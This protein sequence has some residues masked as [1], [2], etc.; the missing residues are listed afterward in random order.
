MLRLQRALAKIDQIQGLPENVMYSGSKAL[1]R[2][3]N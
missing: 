3:Q 2:E 1:L